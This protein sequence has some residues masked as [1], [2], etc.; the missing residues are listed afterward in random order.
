MRRQLHGY[1]H[2]QILQPKSLDLFV[3]ADPFRWSVGP[4]AAP[5]QMLRE[6]V[7]NVRVDLSEG[8]P[9]IPK[10]EVV[11]PALQV[12]IQLLY[13]LRDRLVALPM[14]SHLVQLLPF[15]L[16][17]EEHTSELQSPMYLVC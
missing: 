13:Q 1:Q 12:P 3:E 17:S 7:T 11:L 16:R 15:L 2:L 6:T 5:S 14:I 8:L 9:W 4:L 10:V